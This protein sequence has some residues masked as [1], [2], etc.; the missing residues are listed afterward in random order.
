MQNQ[1]VQHIHDM[2]EDILKGN[3]IDLVK[4]FAKFKDA[5]TVAVHNAQGD[6]VRTMS[7]ARVVIATGSRPRRIEFPGAEHAVTSDEAF[8]LEERPARV[9]IVGGGPVAMELACIFAGLGSHVD[10]VF[11]KALP[12]TGARRH[13]IPLPFKSATRGHRHLPDTA[14]FLG[15][16]ICD[17]MYEAGGARAQALTKTAAARCCQACCAAPRRAPSARPCAS[18]SSPAATCA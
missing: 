10:V 4:G 8:A 17:H 18:T 16:V 13:L 11:R 2:Y 15:A 5:H 7:G 9:A 6:V 14:T 12:L 1:T 3:G